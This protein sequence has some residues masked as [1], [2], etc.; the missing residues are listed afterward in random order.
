[1]P[2]SK[3]STE[4]KYE[5]VLRALR[6]EQVTDICRENGVSPTLFYRWRDD[7]LRGAQEGLKDKRNPQHRDPLAEE[8]RKLKKIVAEQLLVIEGQKKLFPSDRE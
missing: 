8:N 4:K 6:G 3:W 7:F 1:M 2:E 5:L